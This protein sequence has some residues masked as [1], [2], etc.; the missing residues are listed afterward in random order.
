[1]LVLKNNKK[2][3]TII[4]KIIYIYNYIVN[5]N[6]QRCVKRLLIVNTNKYL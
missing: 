6:N 1:M 5:I 2:K 4:T 3:T